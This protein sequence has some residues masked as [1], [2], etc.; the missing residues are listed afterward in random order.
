[1]LTIKVCGAI[2]VAQWVRALVL[3]A[4]NLSLIPRIQRVE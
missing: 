2:P 1:M 3:K 4:N